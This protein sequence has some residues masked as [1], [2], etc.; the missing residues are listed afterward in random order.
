MHHIIQS[1][2]EPL[3]INQDWIKVNDRV[4]LAAFAWL[5][6]PCS[7]LHTALLRCSLLLITDPVNWWCNS[8]VDYSFNV[9]I[10]LPVESFLSLRS[11][12]ERSAGSHCGSTSPWQHVWGWGLTCSLCICRHLLMFSLMHGCPTNYKTPFLPVFSLPDGFMI[13][14]FNDKSL[15]W[16]KAKKNPLGCVQS[17]QPT[18]QGH[19]PLWSA[20]SVWDFTVTGTRPERQVSHFASTP[21][22]GCVQR[23]QTC[24]CLRQ[25][26]RGGSYMCHR[27]RLLWS[28]ASF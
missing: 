5:T 10:T 19:V 13:R 18:S 1:S 25:T 7:C 11:R 16:T 22:S 21:E 9:I 4:K 24:S 27:P 14:N 20:L 26:W 15:A 2:T 12:P 8:A 23:V 6:T 17:P 3:K 28:R